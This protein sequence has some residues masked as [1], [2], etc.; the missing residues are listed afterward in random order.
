LFFRI[1]IKYED[2]PKQNFNRKARKDLAKH[3]KIY[4]CY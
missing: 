2:V 1:T 4:F 3:A